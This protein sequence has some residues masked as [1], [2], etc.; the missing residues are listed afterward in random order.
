[1]IKSYDI[2][3]CTETKTDDLDVLKLPD[4]YS[5]FSKNRK[6]FDKKSGGITVIYK[7]V[8]QR[9]IT[10][11]HNESD[12]V[13]WAKISSLSENIN[14][15]L[16]SIYIPPENSRYF[17]PEVF[18]NLEREFISLYEENM[19]AVYIGDFNART[20]TCSDYIKPNDD[21][22]QILNIDGMNDINDY[23]YDY[24]KL[25]L[26]NI[27][28]E[29]ASEDT[30]RCNSSGTKLLNFCK[31]NSLFICNGRTG[32]DGGT[33]KVTSNRTSLIDYLIV[34]PDLFPFIS[35]F[36]VI[37][38][39]PLLSDVHCRLH[40]TLSILS[41]D[42][43][44]NKDAPEN[45]IQTRYPIRWKAEM[46]NQFVDSVE[47]KLVTN[48]LLNQLDMLDINSASYQ[49]DLN[50][51]V[52]SFNKL[53]I[54][55]A[56][57]TFGTKS[58]PRKQRQKIFQPWFNNECHEKRGKFHEAK[59]K[60]N[61]LKTDETRHA[62]KVACKEYKY[63]MNKCF[64]EHQFK[65]ENDLRKT[66]ETEPK[67]LWKILN[68]MNRS[69]QNKSEIPINELYDYFKNLNTNNEEE[70]YVDFVLPDCDD[71]FVNNILNGEIT[72]DEIISAV[73]NMKN[74]KAPGYDLIVNEY[75]KS[76]VHLLMPLYKKLFN[77]I[78]DSG[79]IPEGW[80]I[81]I[82]LPIYKNKGD[83]LN[84]DNYRGITLVPS[85][86]K[87]F[88]SIIND[89]LSK[90]SDLVEIVPKSQAGFRKGFSTLDNIFVL[91]VLIELYF[92]SG[93]RLYCAFIDFKKAFDTVWR[94]GLW[95][96]LI[97]NKITGKILKVIFNMYDSIK[98]CVKQGSD[99]S[100][101]FSCD[102]GSVKGKIYPLSCFQFSYQ[103]L[104]SI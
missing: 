38:F 23:L 81:G 94:M 63:M 100:G 58:G 48:D 42:D 33:G 46:K 59:K 61:S 83:P 4:G 34:S 82:I 64:H 5:Y 97:Q 26:H 99:I 30:G 74:S 40:V 95:Q 67:E 49:S 12:Y 86:G 75:V 20:G 27:S 70:E 8:L 25:L 102:L 103:I 1:L 44:H 9:Y 21:L 85:V 47:S 29:R 62:L 77:K 57:N 87:L 88:T 53:L 13:L 104:K 66:S 15:L 96:K 2:F 54:E 36:Q 31:N 6:H 91:Y 101:F 32:I 22:V 45:T 56:E 65:L 19:F 93:K 68:N 55:S 17:S 43:L 73:K 60:H 92:S 35:E 41:N 3:V 90:F 69:V 79:S 16:G 71:E 52:E 39:D 10:F 51:F 89:R 7:S 84:P 50:D 98:S 14:I 76:T 28:L 37:D 24:Q 78:L 18:D 11:L 80:T 72:E